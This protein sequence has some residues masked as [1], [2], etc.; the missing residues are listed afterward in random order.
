MSSQTEAAEK[1]VGPTRLCL[2]NKS[3]LKSKLNLTCQGECAVL[4]FNHALLDVWVEHGGDDEAGDDHDG[5]PRRADE[6]DHLVHGRQHAGLQSIG[7]PGNQLDLQEMRKTSDEHG[8]YD[9]IVFH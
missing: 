5:V 9:Q 4:P 7:L 3:I 1:L 6:P 2:W 8:P